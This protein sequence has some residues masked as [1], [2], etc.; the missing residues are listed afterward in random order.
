MAIDLTSPLADL[1]L[2][3]GRNAYCTTY[4]PQYTVIVGCR[5]YIMHTEYL[6]ISSMCNK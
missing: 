2:M 1:R 5:R 6:K 3:A 4:D